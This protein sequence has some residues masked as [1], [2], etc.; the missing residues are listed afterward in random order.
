[1]NNDV[2]T[3]PQIDRKAELP[4]QKIRV[5]HIITQLELGGAQLNTLYTVENL[6]PER[7]ETFLIAGPGGMQDERARKSM[8][9]RFFQIPSMGRTL[10]P[11]KDFK[12]FLEIKKL[13]NELQPDIVHTHSSKA[14]V[15]GRW[16]ANRAGVPHVIHSIH[17]WAFSDF[18][19]PFRNWLYILCERQTARITDRFISVSLINIDEGLSKHI[20]DE[21]EV[22]LIRSG[23]DLKRFADAPVRREAIRKEFGFPENCPLVLMV[24]VFKPQK[25][26]LDFIRVARTL[27]EDMPEVRFLMVG[28]GEL[29]E[30]IEE[31][32]RDTGLTRIV[33]LAGWRGDIPE[34]MK[35]SD[36]LALTSLW[37]GLPQVFP[38]AI[39]AGLPIVA[40]DVDG[41]SEIIHQGVT[42]FLSTPKETH[43]TADLLFT[44]LKDE[45][46]RRSFSEKAQQ[47][48]PDFDQDLMVKKQE[49][50]YFSLCMGTRGEEPW[51]S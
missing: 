1:M 7:F 23:V 42:G 12:A 2:Y 49:A 36:V 46:M 5:V 8:G 50:L 20:F 13:L 44:L 24:A 3:K 25:A 4:P 19:P 26:P 47:Y 18:Q 11:F 33:A 43:K 30:A 9:E 15:L 45:K 32:L 17:G 37:E 51:P 34:L 28:D 14:G 40:T 39:A 48:V 41:A 31:R 29:R 16:A 22:E 10:S 27:H 38:Q 6:D 35:A 21:T